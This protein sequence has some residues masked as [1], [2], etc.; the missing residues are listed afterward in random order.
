MYRILSKQRVDAP[1]RWGDYVWCLFD[2]WRYCMFLLCISITLR[3]LT[4]ELRLDNS[5]KTQ[6]CK[7]AIWLGLREVVIASRCR[8]LTRDQ[9]KHERVFVVCEQQQTS[10]RRI[11]IARAFVKDCS[12]WATAKFSQAS[13]HSNIVHSLVHQNLFLLQQ[14]IFNQLYAYIVLLVNKLLLMMF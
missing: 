8:F 10:R 12:L 11:N 1:T 13:K 3:S 2:R 5:P 4:R 14:I 9:R 7:R 6:A